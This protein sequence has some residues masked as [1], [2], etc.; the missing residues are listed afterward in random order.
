VLDES[1]KSLEADSSAADAYLF[2][3]D[4]IKF[5]EEA[6]IANANQSEIELI[7]RGLWLASHAG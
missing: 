3:S 7:S 4:L 6:R 2:L 5:I 1:L